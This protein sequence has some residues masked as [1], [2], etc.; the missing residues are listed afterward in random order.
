MII[1][2]VTNVPA[3][4]TVTFVTMGAIWFSSYGGY[5]HYHGHSPHGY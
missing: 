1:I 3:V 4:A 2:K 5:S